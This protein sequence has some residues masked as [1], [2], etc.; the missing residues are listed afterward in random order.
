MIIRRESHNGSQFTL[1]DEMTKIKN[2]VYRVERVMKALEKKVEHDINKKNLV[3]HSKGHQRNSN[4]DHKNIMVGNSKKGL[5]KE[6]KAL[7]KEK[8]HLASYLI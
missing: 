5:R 2:Q 3:L 1:E 7:S 6:I 4:S 8:L